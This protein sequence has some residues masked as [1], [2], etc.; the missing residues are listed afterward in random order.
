MAG[1]SPPVHHCGTTVSGST[2]V[3]KTTFA[4]VC[5]S[6]H[7]QVH[8]ISAD[9][10][11][12]PG[13]FVS[14]ESGC[15][16]LPEPPPVDVDCD[17]IRETWA[18]GK[19]AFIPADKQGQ[20]ASFCTPRYSLDRE[21]CTDVAGYFNGHEICN[22]DKNRCEK[23]GGT[24]GAVGTPGPTGSKNEL[25]TTVCIPKTFSDSLPTCDSNGVVSLIF[26][27]TDGSGGFVCSSPMQPPQESDEPWKP[28]E[29]PPTPDPD[30]PDED[31][32]RG[33]TCPGD[34]LRPR[35]PPTPPTTPDPPD[36]D[37]PN[38]DNPQP[39]IPTPP[40]PSTPQVPPSSVRGGGTCASRPICQGDAIQCAIL[41]QT[42]RTRCLIK[43][44]DKFDHPPYDPKVDI[45]SGFDALE[46]VDTAIIDS[47]EGHEAIVDPLGS[48]AAENLESTFGALTQ[49]MPAV[50]GCAPIQWSLPRRG[51][52][53]IS[54]SSL[55]PLRDLL[56]WVFAAITTIYC[57]HVVFQSRTQ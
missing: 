43:K 30:A 6:N 28:P 32:I 26:N 20:V 2:A 55:S 49:L 51:T 3:C 1:L 23:T 11:T 16:E 7:A 40:T 10:C 50:S 35:V 27:S 42:W 29:P 45:N 37:R 47:I 56:G 18:S 41:W 9:I 34:P 53:T 52:L 44:K 25:W 36:P 57:I 21:E 46:A 39:D 5:N 33:I 12:T 8:K 15:S 17:K 4:G 14:D 54:C 19:I 22:D 13:H 38:P 24:Y 48:Q 31:C